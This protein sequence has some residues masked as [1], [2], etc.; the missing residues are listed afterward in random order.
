MPEVA[1][2]TL[3]AQI[4]LK[5]LKNKKLKQIKIRSGRYLNK[6][7]VGFKEF[8]DQLPLTLVNVNSKGKFLYFDLVNDN[9][10]HWYIWNTLGLTGMW[11]F[12]KTEYIRFVFKFGSIKIYFSDMRNFG[13]IKFDNDKNQLDK[14]LKSLGPDFLKDDFDLSKIKKYNLPIINLLMDQK[15][16]GSGLGNYLT[17]EIL[18]HAKISPHRLGNQLSKCDIKRLTY[19]IKYITKLAYMDNHTGYMINLEPEMNTIKKVNYHPEIDIDHKKFSFDVYRKKLDPCGNKVKAEK[20]LKDRT[21]YWV[22]ILQK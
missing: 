22:P 11:S 2:I 8:I 21:T 12:Y 13:T 10:E 1:E 5:Y 16:I 6:E 18:Y 15:K 9:N 14:K 7:P 17:A 19:W 20:I 4:L 3:T